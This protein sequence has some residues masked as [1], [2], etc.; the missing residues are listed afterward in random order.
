MGTYSPKETLNFWANGALKNSLYS[1]RFFWSLAFHKGMVQTLDLR[2]L[3]TIFF[4]SFFHLFSLLPSLFPCNCF[5]IL[6]HSQF[7][8]YVG[9]QYSY[10]Y[11]HWHHWRPSTTHQFPSTTQILWGFRIGGIWG[12]SI[13]PSFVWYLTFIL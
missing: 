4:F 12:K 10:S 11:T 13:L 1:F 7:Y 9:G 8:F 5:V 3:L 2:I 6:F